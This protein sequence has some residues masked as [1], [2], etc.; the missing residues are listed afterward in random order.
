MARRRARP[1]RSGARVSRFSGF[2]VSAV[3]PQATGLAR[4]QQRLGKML[5]HQI[6]VVHDDHH[7]APLA[8]PALDQRDQVGD[9]PGVDGVERLVEQ[10][11]LRV[12]HQHAGKQRALQL[13]ARQRVDRARFEAFEADRHQRVA[14]PSP[15]PRR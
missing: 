10:D 4:Q 15:G 9:G 6:E 14:T 13:A 3:A 11:Q 1:R 8:M 12:L 2:S 7:R 5:A